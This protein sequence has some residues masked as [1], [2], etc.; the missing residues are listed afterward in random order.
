MATETV[1]ENLIAGGKAFVWHEIVAPDIDKSIEFY[2]E[3]LAFETTSME[4]E[5]FGAYHM[6]SRDG[7]PVAGVV[8]PQMPGV[9]SHWATYISVADVDATIE[10]VTEKG[11][12]LVVPAMDIPT[13]GRMALI[14]DPQDAYVWIFKPEMA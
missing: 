4:M 2:T 11:G 12:K 7:Q 8:A 10:K 14:S 3:A 13:I 1:S 9:P 5:G 6:L